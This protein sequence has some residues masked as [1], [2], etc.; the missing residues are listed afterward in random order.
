MFDDLKFYL[1]D[2][3]RQMVDFSSTAQNQ[4]IEPPPVQK[5]VPADAT[6]VVLPSV[7]QC[8][9][10]GTMPLRQ[11]IADRMSRRAFRQE[12]ISLAELAFFLWASQGVRKVVSPAAVF[13]NVPSAGCRH[14]L[15]TYVAAFQV[16]GLAQGLYRYLPLDHALV[17]LSHSENLSQL[18]TRA[19]LGQRFAG[20]S[21][22]T[23]FWTAVPERM[24]WRYAEASYKVIA[25]DA[26]HVCQNL[27]L[28]CESVGAG[29]CAIAA[30]DQGAADALLGV[31]GDTE[32]TVYMAPV[33]KV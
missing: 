16:T 25:L 23:F 7:E 29:T 32:F 26:G 5:P 2:D 6:R 27:Y 4:G 21:A 31:D 20:T 28:A 11:A 19:A 18:V 14:A 17:R 15:E 8:P 12:P 33:G 1:K 10:L 9:D 22:A 13:R 30:Y 3:I 24:E